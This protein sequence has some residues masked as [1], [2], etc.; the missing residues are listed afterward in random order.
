MDGTH[1]QFDL[2]NPVPNNTKLMSVFDQ[3]N[4][5]Y[6]SDTVFMAAQGIDEKWGMRRELLTPQYTTRWGD[7]PLFKCN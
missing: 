6:G 5:R 3:L 7:L 2:L 4:G 1:E